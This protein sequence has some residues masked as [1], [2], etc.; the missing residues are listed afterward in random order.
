MAVSP[1][2]AAGL[3][4]LLGLVLLIMTWLSLTERPPALLDG[5]HADK[6]AHLAAYLVLAL[7]VDLSWSQRAF[8]LPKW[9]SLLAYGVLIELLQSQIPGRVFSVLDIA[10]NA[11]GIGLYAFALVGILRR[12]GVR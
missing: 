1:C 9:G 10:A 12:V 5:E 8:D 6:W 2:N 7:L 11:A 3:R 4:L